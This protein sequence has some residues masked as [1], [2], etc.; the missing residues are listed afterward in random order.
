MTVEFATRE[1][2]IE[3]LKNT[4]SCVFLSI[5][6]LN[7]AQELHVFGSSAKAIIN[8]PKTEHTPIF[9]EEG[10]Y[11]VEYERAS[12]E[13]SNDLLYSNTAIAWAYEASLSR[14]PNKT[15]GTLKTLIKA[16][17]SF[18]YRI[19]IKN[20]GANYSAYFEIVLPETPDELKSL[21]ETLYQLS[22]CYVFTDSSGTINPENMKFGALKLHTYLS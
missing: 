20:K 17:S 1:K 10:S 15:I 22:F 9:F 3:W 5:S 16:F 2:L 14:T 19:Q 21:E 13:E 7:G 12:E 11:L 8:I 4:T 6:L 18:E